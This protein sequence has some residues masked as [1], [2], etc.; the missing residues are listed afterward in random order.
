MPTPRS[1]RRPASPPSDSSS[2]SES[3]R[4]ALAYDPSLMDSAPEVERFFEPVH[5]L[6]SKAFNFFYYVG[7]VY[8]TL[9]F[10]GLINQPLF[11]NFNVDLTHPKDASLN[12]ALKSLN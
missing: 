5:P 6:F 11:T 7:I 3:D 10:L 9:L 2:E 8:I 1:V 4:G 12:T